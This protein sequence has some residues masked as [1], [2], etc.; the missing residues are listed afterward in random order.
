MVQSN[1]S[2]WWKDL[3]EVY[4]NEQQGD[5]F[6]SRLL[7]SLRD[8]RNV[9]FWEDRWIECKVLKEEFHRLFTI[10]QCKDS[11]VFNVVDSGQS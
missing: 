3:C 8:R 10:S 6:D 2:Q 11:E 9:K 4:R 1:Q 5:W 7:W